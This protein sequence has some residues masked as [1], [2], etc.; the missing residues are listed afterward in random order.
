MEPE[1]NPDAPTDDQPPEEGDFAGLT[2]AQ[3]REFV[4]QIP[5]HAEKNC[6]LARDL[7][8]V[9]LDY[10]AESIPRLDDLIAENWPDKPPTL[11]ENM[12]LAY[13]SYLGETIRTLHGGDW[14]HSEEM[15][16]HLDIEGLKIFPFAKVR[17]R[18]INGKED[19]LGFF[20]QFVWTE[21]SKRQNPFEEI[22]IESPVTTP[23]SVS[24]IELPPIGAVPPPSPVVEPVAV[25]PP[26]PPPVPKP[27][28]IPRL[29][30]VMP[31]LPVAKKP[32]RNW[33]I[34]IIILLL[35]FTVMAVAGLVGF[36]VLRS[37]HAASTQ[38]DATPPAADDATNAPT[39]PTSVVTDDAGTNLTI[40]SAKF[41]AGKKDADVTAKVIELLQAHPEG[42]TISYKTLAADPAQGKKKHL[43]VTYEY[44][45]VTYVMTLANGKKLSNGALV[46]NALK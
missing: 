27:P 8:G 42:F 16:F 3:V 46:K 28:P 26:T 25:T 21:L 7:N 34:I 32:S 22:P 9:V 14:C 39:T 1:Q 35:G 36:R 13:G 4:V 23:P 33:A 19:S 38:S 43:T 40:V 18:F 29:T 15:G 10:T 5:Q 45:G 44:K 31:P 2:E 24:P 12:V 41:V 17:R 30:P 37:M 11:L 6:E 20:Y